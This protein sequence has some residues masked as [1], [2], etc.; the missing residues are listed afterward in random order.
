MKLLILTYDFPYPT[1]SGGKSRVYNLI[2]FLKK[3]DIEIY[4]L[5]FIRETYKKKYDDSLF[6][7]GVTEIYHFK[8]KKIRSFPVIFKASISSKSIFEVLYKDKK[9][10]QK[11]MDLIREKDID[12]ILFESFYTS[13]YISDEI[14]KMKVRQIFGTENIEHIL[15]HDFAI[16]KSKVAKRIY[17]SQV[18]KIKKE[19]ELAYKKSDL[20]LAVS[21][22]EKSYMSK[23]TKTKIEV[24]PNGV[25]SSYFSFKSH[26][27]GEKKLLFVGNFSYFPNIDAMDFFYKNVFLNIPNA[28]L[29]VVGKS[30]NKLP[31]LISDN[32]VQNIEYA[33]DLAK[34]YYD[35]DIFVFPVRFGGGTNF[36]VLEAASCGTPIIA[37]PNRVNGL[38]FI[39]DTHFVE[40]TSPVDFMRG[41]RRLTEDEELQ[42][43]ITKNARMLIEKKYDWKKIGEKLGTVLEAV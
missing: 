35:S 3:K 37:I 1:T 43:T 11:I 36:K 24:I 33:E 4:L 26:F 42:K 7:I 39:P 21:D 15:Y 20:I 32:R 30:Q 18:A 27:S 10:K 34:V 16:K 8:R 6:D 22:E 12:V 38:G 28:S 5:S 19:E 25:D 14:K 13:F 23:Q 41:I 31:F 17:M 40:A 9:V 2:K 29:T